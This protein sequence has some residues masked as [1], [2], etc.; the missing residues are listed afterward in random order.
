VNNVTDVLLA[1]VNNEVSVGGNL[2]GVVDTGESLDLSGTGT[3]VD[4][5]LVGLLA[6][7]EGSGNVDKEDGSGSLHGGTGNL[8]GLLVGS[9][10]GSD[11]SGTGTGKLGGDEGNTL[12]VLV[13]VLLGESELSGELLTDLLTEKESGGT[14]SL[15]VEGDLEGTSDGVLSGVDVS[16]EE[17]GESL[18]V[19]GRVRLAENL[20]DLRVGKPLGDGSSGTETATELG[21]GDV[22]GL[23]T[24]LDL[25]DGH[26][27]V[28]VGKVG[29]HLERNDL[30][31]DLLLVLLNGV[32]GVVRTV[33]VNTLRVGSGTGVVT[34]NN[35]VGSSVVLTDDSVPDSLT[36]TG[37]THG[38]GKETEGGH[39][40]GV[41]GEKGLVDTDTGEVVNVTGLGESD[42]GV[43]Q[44]VGL[45]VTGSADSQLSVSTVHGVTGLESDDLGP[46]E[47][48]EVSAKLGGGVYE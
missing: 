36:G 37:H 30:N 33:E 8:A 45:T 34:S 42:D 47:L 19:T 18:L 40:V 13:A 38:Q 21:S 31:S 23:G 28:G 46:S 48:L 43:D 41:A 35:E 10:G 32:L 14:S 20:D 17:D 1:Y 15:L 22:E 11:D 4:T 3:G 25:V 2:V 26:V 39:S 24:G 44:D 6:E 9:D 12:E 27:L 7:L 29:H 16:S 5:T